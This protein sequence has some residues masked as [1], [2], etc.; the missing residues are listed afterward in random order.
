[1]KLL[2]SQIFLWVFKGIF[3]KTLIRLAIRKSSNIKKHTNLLQLKNCHLPF[4]I[5]YILGKQ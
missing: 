5:P 3:M 2:D 1:M 4:L